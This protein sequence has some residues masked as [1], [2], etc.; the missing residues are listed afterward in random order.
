MLLFLFSIKYKGRSASSWPDQV[1]AFL[2]QLEILV[3]FN[4]RIATES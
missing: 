4:A 3:Y 2:N 1:N